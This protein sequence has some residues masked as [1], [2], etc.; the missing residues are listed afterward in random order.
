MPLESRQR[1]PRGPAWAHG[2]TMAGPR[3]GP[4]LLAHEA[5]APVLLLILLYFL[6]KN[7]VAVRVDPFVS[8]RSLKFKNTQNRVSCFAKLETNKRGP[9][10]K[11]P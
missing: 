2:A 10:C 5:P 4:Y 9:C 7:D 8:V 6:E 11:F 1:G 3:H